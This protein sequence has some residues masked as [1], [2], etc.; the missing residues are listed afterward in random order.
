MCCGGIVWF[1]TKHPTDPA[2]ERRWHHSLYAY[3]RCGQLAAAAALQTCALFVEYARIV[4]FL[5][6]DRESGLRQMRMMNDITEF[7]IWAWSIQRQHHLADSLFKWTCVCVAASRRTTQDAYVAFRNKIE[8][9][10]DMNIF[11]FFVFN[12]R[13]LF[14]FF[15]S[16]CIFYFRGIIIRE[17]RA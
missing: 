4:K 2:P 7:L 9:H 8:A 3:F 5:Q 10:L 1:P 11:F 6:N 13:H 14:P 12:L 16:I 17:H 15:A